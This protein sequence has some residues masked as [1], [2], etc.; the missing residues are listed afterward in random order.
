MSLVVNFLKGTCMGAADVVPGVSGG[1]MA[2]ILGIYERLLN[3]I[4]A[5]DLSWLAM[6]LRG[7]LRPAL[8]K[9]D[10]PLIVPLLLGIAAALAFFTRVVP[11]PKLIV[12]HPELVIRPKNSPYTSSG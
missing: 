3:A 1:T 12:S 6:L 11:L 4:R 5:V 7:H 2:L 8:A 9:L 10:L